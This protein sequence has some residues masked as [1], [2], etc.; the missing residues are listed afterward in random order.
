MGGSSVMKRILF[1][2]L[3]FVVSWVV[4]SLIY[5]II[6]GIVIATS[7]NAAGYQG[8]MQA[9]VAF[10]HAHPGF[11]IGM[12]LLILAIAILIAVIGSWKRILP[13]TRM[14]PV[15]TAENS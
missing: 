5:G 2:I 12:R 1:G 7:H 3:W 6:F 15:A 9:A 4:L 13:G 11:V 10:G 14:K 8:G